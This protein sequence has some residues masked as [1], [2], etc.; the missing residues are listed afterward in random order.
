M[1]APDRTNRELIEEISALKQRIKEL[2][3]TERNIPDDKYTKETL[4]KTN[5]IFQELSEHSLVGVYLMQE[6]GLFKYVNSRCAEIFGYKV[7]EVVDR[8]RADQVVL[9]EDWPIVRQSLSKRIS[10]ELCSQHYEFRMLTRDKDTKHVEVFSCITE[11]ENKPAIVGTL[12][13][14]T[15]R[16]RI[17]EALKESEHKYR[18]LAD[19]TA[20]V[21]FTF[22]LDMKYKYISP[23]VKK[24]GGFSP[25]E[26]IGRPVGHF[27][28]G[29]SL[30]SI[31]KIIGEELELDKTGTADPNRIKIVETER[32]RKDGSI[33]WTEVKTSPLRNGNG[34]VEGIIGI[35]RDITERK[36]AEQEREKLISELKETLAKVKTLN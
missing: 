35:A 7:E 19:N 6:D 28:K 21:I 24:I 10:G 15:E 30:E 34:E 29:E 26:F 4:L 12:L 3:Q 33:M 27:M 1:K 36:L 22:G 16:K 20:D 9:P 13:D 14:I 8:L 2:E 25:E 17:E 18:L 23:S 5:I 11:Y 31:K 32:Y